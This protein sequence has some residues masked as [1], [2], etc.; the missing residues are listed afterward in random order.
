MSGIYIKGMKESDG[1]LDCVLRL[2]NRCEL[3][4]NVW[5]AAV[6]SSEKCPII[7]VP[8]HRRLGDL[9]ALREAVG[10]VELKAR[11]EYC[12]LSDAE[13]ECEYEMGVWDGIHMAAKIL[14]TAP[15]IIPLCEEVYDKYTDTAGNLHWTGTH[16]GKHIIPAG[17]EGE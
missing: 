11:E 15:T 2:A 16:S 5:S 14:S 1:C 8:D 9:D 3:W 10:E 13:K 6:N 17:K 4:K 7:P 12:E